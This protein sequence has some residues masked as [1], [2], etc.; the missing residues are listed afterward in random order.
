MPFPYNKD[1]TRRKSAYLHDLDCRTTGQTRKAQVN[2]PYYATVTTDEAIEQGECIA[3][4][5]VPRNFRVTS[6]QVTWNVPSAADVILGF[7]DPFACGRLSNGPLDARSSSNPKAG[8]A[9]S[10]ASCGILSKTGNIGDGCGIGYRY[11]CETDL[12]ITNLY[13]LQSH[14]L[15]G[16]AGGAGPNGGGVWGAA[17]PSGSTITVVV[18]GFVDPE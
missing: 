11:T 5:R 7:G 17:L 1:F 4:L 12:V 15:G 3:M 10:F 14:E 8:Y 16:F 2:P 18:D 9:G 6:A 13:G